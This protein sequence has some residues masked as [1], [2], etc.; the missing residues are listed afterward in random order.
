MNKQTKLIILRGPSGAGKSTVAKDL[1]KAAARPTAYIEQDHYRFMFQPPGGQEGEVKTIHEIILQTALTALRDGYDVILE[2]ILNRPSYH[3]VFEVL[4]RAHPDN[5]Y[6]FYFD[7]SFDETIRRHRLR[8]TT[9]LFTEEDMRGWY[10]DKDVLGYDFERI[11][12]EESTATQTVA[13]IREITD[14]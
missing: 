5:N 9:N 6:A 11:I 3:E 14:I 13:M 4:V 1:F 2:G 8:K 12:S 10:R 7:V